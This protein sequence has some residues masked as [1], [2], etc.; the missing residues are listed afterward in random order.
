MMKRTT[1]IF[2]A[3]LLISGLAGCN[4]NNPDDLA[5]KIVGQWELA[6]A[7]FPTRSVTVGDEVLTVYVDFQAG[8]VFTLYQQLGE[9]RFEVFDGSW[10]YDKP[11]IGSYRYKNGDVFDGT[12]DNGV[13]CNGIYY[14]ANGDVYKGDFDENGRFSGMGVYTWKNGEKY[15]GHWHQGYRNGNGTMY[16]KN[17]TSKYCY[18]HKNQPTDW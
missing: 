8:G 4:K 13:K 3:A 10:Q 18:W 7:E 16:Y 17:G 15:D 14:F 5:A 2:A 6:G 12:F 11:R 1:L 9:G